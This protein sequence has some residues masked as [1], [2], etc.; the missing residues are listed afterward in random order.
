MRT[1]TYRIPN[2]LKRAFRKCLCCKEEF[3]S[4]GAHHRICD[5]CKSLN[6]SKNSSLEN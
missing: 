5:R 1:N 2:K 3:N 4:E 6:K